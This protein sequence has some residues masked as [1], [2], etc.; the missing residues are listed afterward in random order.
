[1][2]APIAY[3]M[4]PPMAVEPPEVQSIKSM[5]HIAKILAI[6]LGILA[7]LGGIAYAAFLVFA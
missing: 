5:L 6:I 4:P 1:M 3:Q 2:G 7:L